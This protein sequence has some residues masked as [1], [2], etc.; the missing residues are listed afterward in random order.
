V[1]VVLVPL[2]VAA[3]V[4]VA[5]VAVV[6]VPQLPPNFVNSWSSFVAIDDSR[7]G[8]LLIVHVDHHCPSVNHYCLSI[9][10]PPFVANLQ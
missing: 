10:Q 5:V 2:S 7:E 3:V 4:V 6:E 9:R 8:F 1:L